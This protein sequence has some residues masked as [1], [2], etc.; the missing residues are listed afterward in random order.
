MIIYTPI[1][2]EMPWTPFFL[3]HLLEYD[4]P[5]IIC[6]GASTT[7]QNGNCRSWD[8]SWEIIKA[9]AERWKDRVQIRLHNYDLKKNNFYVNEKYPREKLKVDIWNELP[10]K[11]WMV[12]LS[13]DNFYMP[14]DIK[15]LKDEF[16]CSNDYVTLLTG[17]RVFVF[18]FKTVITHAIPTLCGPWV[19]TW[20]CIWK[21]NDT[22]FLNSKSELMIDPSTDGVL[23]GTNERPANPDNLKFIHFRKDIMQFHYKGVKPFY[24]RFQRFSGNE[25]KIKRYMNQSVSKEPTFFETYDG[26]HHLLLD[27]HPYRKIL[28]ARTDMTCFKWEDFIHIV[29]GV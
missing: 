19:N 8:G 22:F 29:T 10:D 26:E 13:P 24:N 15:K 27:G 7:I 23:V 5:I 14:H 3:K 4:C 21:K 2:N 25:E 11:E 1:Y 9:F 18:N 16:S 28:D 20:P 17:M 6:E 12:G